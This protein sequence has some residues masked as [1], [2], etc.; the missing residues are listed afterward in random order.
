MYSHK[1]RKRFE[2]LSKRIVFGPHI[3]ARMRGEKWKRS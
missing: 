2:E 1:E 3:S